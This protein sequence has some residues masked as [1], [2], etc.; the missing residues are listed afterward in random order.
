MKKTLESKDPEELD[1]LDQEIQMVLEIQG[2]ESEW[3]TIQPKNIDEDEDED[4][5]EEN[6]DENIDKDKNDEDEIKGGS[7]RFHDDDWNELVKKDRLTLRE[8]ASIWEFIILLSSLF[9]SR[10]A[11]FFWTS[12]FQFFLI[13]FSNLTFHICN[14]CSVFLIKLSSYQATGS[15]IVSRIDFIHAFGRELLSL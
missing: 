3:I 10:S 11:H 15:F 9:Y 6:K 14:V 12:P 4:E 2:K 13:V 1:E 7:F 8:D 5:E